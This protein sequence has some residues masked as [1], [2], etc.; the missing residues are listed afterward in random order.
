MSWIDQF[1]KSYTQ[2]VSD[3]DEEGW[4]PFDPYLFYPYFAD[5]FLEKLIRAQKKAEER[6]I[7]VKELA[8]TFAGPITLRGEIQFL[9]LDVKGSNYFQTREG[10]SLLDFFHNILKAKCTS[11]IYGFKSARIH[12]APEIKRIAKS[13]PW[14]KPNLKQAQEVGKLI[15]ACSHLSWALYTDYCYLQ[16]YEIFGPYELSQNRTLLIR[17]YSNFRPKE[18]WPHFKKFP[19]QSVNIYTIYKNVSIE[20]DQW[21]HLKSKDNLIV[22]MENIAIKVNSRLVNDFK[23]INKIRKTI[24]RSAQNLQNRFQ[25]MDFEALKKKVVELRYYMYKDFFSKVGM[26]WRPEKEVWEKIKNK[27][28]LPRKYPRFKNTDHAKKYWSQFID[29]RRK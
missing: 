3:S 26:S 15:S 7:S 27:K 21:S 23:T 13:T 18:V 28:L 25:K 24:E 5:L 1:I 19:Y 12:T 29:P 20:L 6:N 11:D 14:Q 16:W 8:K 17:Q 4:Y 10:G 2:A 9:F 22:A